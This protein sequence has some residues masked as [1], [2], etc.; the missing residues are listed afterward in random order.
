MIKARG[1]QFDYAILDAD[2][3]VYACG[4]AVQKTDK[5]TGIVHCEPAKH[6][7]YN[8]NHSFKKAL[9]EIGAKNYEVY[10]T[11]KNN[12]R[13]DIY[14]YYKENRVKCLEKCIHP[15]DCE[16][17]KVDARPVYYKQ[18]RQFIEKRW[19][20]IVYDGQEADDS[21]S[22]RHCDLNPL[23]FKYNIYNSVIVSIDKDFNNV[24]GYKYNPKKQELTYHTEVEALRNFYLQILCGDTSDNVPRVKKGWRKARVEEALNN[25]DTEL[26]MYDII[27]SECANVLDDSY[28]QTRNFIDRNGKLVWLRRR[29]NELW[30]CPEVKD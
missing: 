5:E 29:E 30:Q 12:F 14:K 28:E 26:E 24:P 10:L 17:E 9:Y 2:P 18:I 7:F 21:V 6:A 15:Y 4:F 20:G 16:H 3:Y 13:K 27:V 22:I 23:G 25:V 8:V 19:E 1:I 11:G